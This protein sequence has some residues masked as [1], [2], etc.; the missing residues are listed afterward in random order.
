MSLFCLLRDLELPWQGSRSRPY[1]LPKRGLTV[2]K[3]LARLFDWEE[4]DKRPI[5]VDS[6]LLLIAL[7]A[8]F[9]FAFVF[10]DLRASTLMNL[11]ES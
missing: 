1:E 10:L 7:G 11:F 9:V 3:L 2:A 4:W 6:A 8:V 5:L